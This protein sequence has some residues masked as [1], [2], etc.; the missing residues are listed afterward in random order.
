MFG[1]SLEAEQ[2][3]E[4]TEPAHDLEEHPTARECNDLYDCQ[5]RPDAD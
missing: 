5:L 2:G 1:L 3:E 4:D